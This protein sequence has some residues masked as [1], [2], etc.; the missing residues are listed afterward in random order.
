MEAVVSDILQSRKREPGG[1]K[2]TAL[3]SVGAHG[4]ALAI[5][6][7]LPAIMPAPA[8]QPRVV[9]NI[10]LGGTPG[11][12]TGGTQMLG[13]RRIDAAE[14]STAPQL[15]RPSQISP[16]VPPAMTLPDPR[17]K[18]RTPPR[19]TAASKDP[20]GTAA[21]RGAEARAGTTR[22]ETGAKGQ[23]FGLSSGGGGGDGVKLDTTNFCCP[24]YILDM[25][26]RITR[27][28]VQQQQAAGVVLMK[29]TI[30]RSGQI[31][32]IEVETSSGNPTLDLASQR[33]LVN[34]RMLAPL[35]AA[36]PEPQLTVHLTFDYQRR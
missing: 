27:N 8:P 10:S 19:T 33:A 29:Y 21:G 22:V 1:L 18:P 30:L 31:T 23:G 2:Q 26:D 9:M 4:A 34:T 36:F 11:P 20:R 17:Q 3:L 16:P 35:P 24:E 25:R 12:R 13:G 5:V 6:A 14:P 32:A 15:A 28:W 7:L